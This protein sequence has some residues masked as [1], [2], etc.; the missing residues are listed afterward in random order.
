VKSFMQ[1]LVGHPYLVLLASGLLERVGAPLLFS[2]VLVAAGALA[3]GGHLR[4]DVA[5][6][7]A[8]VTCILGDTLWYEIGR[9]KGD[10]V[11]AMLCR[12]SLEP[13]SCVRRSKVFFEKGVNRTLIFSKWLPG[14]SHVVPA[15]AGLSGIERQHF[16]AANTAG[17]A[18]WIIV[19]MLA[20][21]LPV[22][23][24]HVASA[25]G[26][27][28]FEASVAVLALN[29]GIKYMQRR[30]FLKE[31][32]KS[33]ITPE[34]VRRMLDSGQSIVILDLRH[35]LDSISDERTLPGAIRVL[36]AEVTSRADTL[37]RN[38]EII[39]YCT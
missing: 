36:P 39:L 9:K 15:V 34:E 30:Q 8:L 17:S 14:V 27:I 37:P 20:G 32:Y 38:E 6:W 24:L 28:L 3:A 31:L 26:P 23:R 18:L 13:D 4:F 11:L 35:P 16:F 19:L 7:I 10:R 1:L 29:V 21:Y 22:E 25:V 2:P 33:R 5:V 12:I